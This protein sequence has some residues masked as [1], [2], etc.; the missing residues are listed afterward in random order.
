MVNNSNKKRALIKPIEVLFIIL[1]LIICIV[2]LLFTNNQNTR[3]KV[4]A[5]I[6]Y[7][8]KVVKTIDL[9]QAKDSIF[10]LE[11][12]SNV[13]FEIKDGK[14]RFIDTKCPDKLCENIG[15]IYKVNS[16]AICLPNKVSLKIVGKSDNVDIMI[17]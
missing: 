13:S 5:Q 10:Q 2:F 1:L 15:F 7:D 8:G 17:N 6:S 4:I 9:S 12:N 16:V 14:I 11:T 3:M